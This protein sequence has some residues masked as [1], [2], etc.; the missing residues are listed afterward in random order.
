MKLTAKQKEVIQRM[1]EGWEM[2][3]KAMF[4]AGGG[5]VWIEKDGVVKTV[6]LP[7]FNKLTNGQIILYSVKGFDTT[8]YTLTELGKSIKL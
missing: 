4:L 2:R 5:G 1:R 3:R 6:T 8:E 7:T